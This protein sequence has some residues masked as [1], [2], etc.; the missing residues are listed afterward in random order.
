VS[1]WTSLS[2]LHKNGVAGDITGFDACSNDS[3]AGVAVPD[4]L[5]TGKDEAITG[6]PD[7][8]EMGTKEEMADAIKIDWNGIVNAT[9]PAIAPDYIVCLPGTYGYD[10]DWGP[11]VPWPSSTLFA[12]PDF[13]PTIVINGSSPLPTDG[14]GTLIVTGNLTF[15]G[16]DKWDGIILVGGMIKDNGSGN[17]AGAV[18]TGLNIKRPEPW[19]DTV[20]VSSK[21]EGT[22]DYTFDSCK[23]AAAAA[24]QSKLSHIPNAWIDNWTSW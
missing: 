17:I 21:A 4:G 6:D 14:K 5:M 7:V 3:L 9:N 16:G 2:G 24:G 8:L 12:N 1:A 19:P 13:W 23:V 20:D 11:C 22:K 10:P 18:V 15:G